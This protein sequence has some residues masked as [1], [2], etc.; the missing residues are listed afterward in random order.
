M[1]ERK[2]ALTTTRLRI[3]FLA[4]SSIQF[5]LKI[6]WLWRCMHACVHA[7]LFGSVIDGA[8]QY[9]VNCPNDPKLREMITSKN[10]GEGLDVSCADPVFG[11]KYLS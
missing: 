5:Y 1:T 3:P 10:V 2:I 4:E 9:K 6:V 8:I 7:M 11:N